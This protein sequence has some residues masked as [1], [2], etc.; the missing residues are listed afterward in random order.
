MDL[1]KKYGIPH[2]FSVTYTSKNADVV[3]SNEFIDLMIEKGCFWGW[4]FLYMPV[5]GEK[6]DISLML[7]P[8]Q[9]YRLWKRHLEIRNEKPIVTI[10]FWGDAPLVGGCIAGKH[11]IHIN[12]KGNVEPCIFTHFATDN[13]KE[14]P[15]KEIMASPIF[16]KYR[17]IQPYC[18]N[19]LLPCLL[20]DHPKIIRELVKEFNLYP[21]HPQ[22]ENF[23]KDLAPK[24]DEYSKKVHSFMDKVWKE[25]YDK[26]YQISSC[27]YCYKGKTP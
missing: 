18:Q 15:L 26:S 22:A 9:R 20:I 12:N 10:D 7:S 4:Y 6:E 21:T 16:K 24:I 23:I 3:A 25:N 5:F 2:G 8:E 13:I 14:K 27:P 1:L 11:Y 19:L 17:Q